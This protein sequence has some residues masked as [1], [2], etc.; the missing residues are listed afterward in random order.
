VSRMET[1]G[2]GEWGTDISDV[3]RSG[4]LGGGDGDDARAAGGDEAPYAV[5]VGR[6][7]KTQKDWR[8]PG[9]GN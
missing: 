5:G 6:T 7:E 8:D 4:G 2:L 3:T 1:Q 9:R